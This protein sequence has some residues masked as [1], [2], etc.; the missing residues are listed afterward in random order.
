[1]CFHSRPDVP[2]PSA[3]RFQFHCFTAGILFVLIPAL[4]FAAAPSDDSSAAPTVQAPKAEAGPA[5]DDK[6]KDSKKPGKYDIAHIGQRGIG[7]GFNLYSAKRELELGRNLAAGFDRSTKIIHDQAVNDYINRLAQKIVRYSD[8][9]VPF[10]IKVIDSGDIPRAYGLPGGFLYVDSALIL[11]ADDEAELA[12]I[13]AHEI[14]HVAARHATRAL[15]RKQVCRFVD[16]LAY[17][18]GP[19]GAG[20]ADVGGL[21]GPLSV[22]KF[23]RDAEYEADLLGIEYA[24]SAGYDPQ[25]LLDALEKL[26]AAEELKKAELAKIPGS[27]FA[28]KLPFHSAVMKGFS[29]Y[30]LTEERIQRL[31]SEIS[32]FLPN[33]KDYILDTDE[34]QE[35]KA[36]L[37][38]AQ[39]PVLRHHSGDED[40][41]GPVLRRTTVDSDDN[42]GAQPLRSFAI[43]P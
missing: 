8:A 37:L 15:T 35:V 25:A 38:A 21:A 27:H 41:K 33:R 12:A 42:S 1:M 31:Q 14:G 2:R 40:N 19:A 24:Y 28:S 39:T 11:S 32:A 10:T 26:H 23:S 13:M 29:N 5:Q 22:K 34:F 16:S 20:I 6:D 30:P 17:M 3:R 7:H 18:T 36:R 4:A 43:L 9:E